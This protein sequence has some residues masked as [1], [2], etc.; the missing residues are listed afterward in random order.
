MYLHKTK[1]YGLVST[2][3]RRI[4]APTPFMEEPMPTTVN[5]T[6]TLMVLVRSVAPCL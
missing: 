1:T 4:A 2:H 6:G 5:R 3:L